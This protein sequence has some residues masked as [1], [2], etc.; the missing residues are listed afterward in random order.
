M[1][2]GSQQGPRSSSSVT[3]ND[4]ARRTSVTAIFSHL[5]VG[6]DPVQAVLDRDWEHAPKMR[7]SLPNLLDKQV[8]KATMDQDKQMLQRT[9]FSRSC[10]KITGQVKEVEN[11]LPPM[12]AHSLQQ[13]RKSMSVKAVKAPCKHGKIIH[14]ADLD[15]EA[16]IELSNKLPSLVHQ[17]CVQ[18]DVLANKL[19][20]IHANQPMFFTSS[21][22]YESLRE[23]SFEAS[24]AHYYFQKWQNELEPRW[25]SMPSKPS[26][27]A[28]W[29]TTGLLAELQG[30][31]ARMDVHASR[32]CGLLQ[33]IVTDASTGSS[34]TLLRKHGFCSTV[35]LHGIAD[36]LEQLLAKTHWLVHSAPKECPTEVADELPMIRTD[37]LK[38]RLKTRPTK[39]SSLSTTLQSNWN[40][41]AASS[42][43]SSL[44][45]S[46][47]D[48][49]C[50]RRTWG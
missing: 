5:E 10:S 23:I 24:T 31:V 39:L 34:A 12:R 14:L 37:S 29:S 21:S 15:D 6:R 42:R 19:K 9:S 3:R 33:N 26:K 50:F 45:K 48:V 49:P 38:F 4:G 35:E 18:M 17:T 43:S 27:L 46:V 41:S 47:E 32:F 13:S 36:H 16:L 40:H 2:G 7:A 11:L 1:L 30:M 44:A 22:L 20:D 25:C 28:D 8:C